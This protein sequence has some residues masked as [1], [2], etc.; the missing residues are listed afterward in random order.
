MKEH[1]ELRSAFMTMKAAEV[2]TVQ[3]IPE[4]GCARGLSR[5]PAKASAQ[6]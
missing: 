6:R 1:P 4:P 5:A 3:V 2:Y